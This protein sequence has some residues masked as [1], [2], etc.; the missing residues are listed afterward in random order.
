MKHL[1]KYNEGIFSG[2]TKY[3]N[4]LIKYLNDNIDQ[5]LLR[6]P[7]EYR[8]SGDSSAFYIQGILE[9]NNNN[10]NIEVN[11]MSSTEIRIRFNFPGSGNNKTFDREDYD[12]IFKFVNDEIG[13]QV[14]SVNKIQSFY[15]T[16]SM[17]HV[18][19]LLIYLSDIVGDFKIK[20]DNSQKLYTIES[21]RV[22]TFNVVDKYFNGNYS[23]LS[24]ELFRVYEELN[25]L[26]KRVNDLDCIVSYRI[27]DNILYIAIYQKEDL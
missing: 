13:S 17:E 20:K 21:N 11:K 25:S 26:H 24:D 5:S 12:N 27:L 18:K 16:L 1:I 8:G 9:K 10:I 14:D 6:K 3:A 2:F 15:E 4:S 7:F 19:D 22:L 23:V